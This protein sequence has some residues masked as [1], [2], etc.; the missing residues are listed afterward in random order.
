MIT[1]KPHGIKPL[2]PRFRE[3]HLQVAT[4]MSGESIGPINPLPPLPHPYEEEIHALNWENQSTPE[5][6]KMF[7]LCEPRIYQPLETTPLV[8]IRTAED[9][10]NMIREIVDDPRCREVAI[11]LEHHSQHSYRGI[12]CLIQM[13]TRSKDFIIDPVNL[14]DELVRLNEITADPRI[15]KVLHGSDSDVIWLQRDFA[16]YLVNLFDTGQ[17]ARVL[18]TPGGA[19][20]ANL[21]MFYC[22]IPHTW[23]DLQ[24][25]VNPLPRLVHE[26]ALEILEV[27]KVR[28]VLDRQTSSTLQKNSVAPVVEL[29]SQTDPIPSQIEEFAP[30]LPL[31]SS[32]RSEEDVDEKPSGP[33][34]VDDQALSDTNDD[35]YASIDR[36]A[37]RISVSSSVRRRKRSDAPEA[38]R[39]DAFEVLVAEGDS[40][41]RNVKLS[42][43][44]DARK[45]VSSGFNGIIQ[46]GRLLA[47]AVSTLI[48]QDFMKSTEP[49]MISSSSRKRSRAELERQEE[50]PMESKEPADKIK[51][52]TSYEV[53]ID[54]AGAKR[55]KQKGEQLLSSMSH[56]DLL[57]ASATKSMAESKIGERPKKRRKTQKRSENVLATALLETPSRQWMKRKEQVVECE[58]NASNSK[59]E[60]LKATKET[61]KRRKENAASLASF[62]ENVLDRAEKILPAAFSLKAS[63]L[64]TLSVPKYFASSGVESSKP[65]GSSHSKKRKKWK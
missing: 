61:K 29:T 3:A 59:S 34:D 37:V 51:F 54:K 56:P 4:L 21:L 45:K 31:G 9:L 36:P 30:A 6:K 32:M 26:K 43:P 12:T 52:A 5:G 17:A 60:G 8:M 58:T 24:S 62:S 65:K 35:S 48:S 25:L 53:L 27:I 2:D 1:A 46:Q 11:D 50:S 16:V 49:M 44:I 64:S 63:G 19:S 13:S 47:R 40:T 14:Q 57:E 7:G 28:N 42:T 22:K 23:S 15:V 38:S 55:K 39:A 33:T 20:L 18:E 10:D 41:E